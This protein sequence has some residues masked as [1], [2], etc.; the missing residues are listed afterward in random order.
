MRRLLAILMIVGL[1]GIGAG[2]NHTAGACDCAIGPV[3]DWVP[4]VPKGATGPVAPEPI[5]S[6]PRGNP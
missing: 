1:T 6:M 5:K 2:C 4:P 3:A